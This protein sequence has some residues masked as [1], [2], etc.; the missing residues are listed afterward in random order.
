MLNLFEVL[1]ITMIFYWFISLV[2]VSLVMLSHINAN[3][4]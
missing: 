1:E 4:Q 2:Q 3:P